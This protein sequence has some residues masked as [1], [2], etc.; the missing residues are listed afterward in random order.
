MFGL[1]A[2][3]LCLCQ[4]FLEP[5][6]QPLFVH[7]GMRIF[8]ALEQFKKAPVRLAMIVNEY[9]SLEGIVT[10]TDLLEAIAGEAICAEVEGEEP[11]VVER[12]DGSLLIDG[13]MS[14]QEAFDRLNLQTRPAKHHCRLHA[15]AARPP[16]QAG[17]AL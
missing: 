9:G 16:A 2:V 7:E 17:R 3:R 12:E 6:S 1:G 8:K 15:P 10:Q 4:I 11:D 13:M 5:A 14:A